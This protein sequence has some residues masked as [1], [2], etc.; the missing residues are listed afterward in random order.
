MAMAA[1]P[2]VPA[3]AEIATPPVAPVPP[4]VLAQETVRHLNSL[5]LSRSVAPIAISNL[6][7]LTRLNLTKGLS[8]LNI[9]STLNQDL[10]TPKQFVNRMKPI[11]ESEKEILEA[12]RKKKRRSK[13][14]LNNSRQVI[15]I[16]PNSLNSVNPN[17]NSENDNDSN[18]TLLAVNERTGENRNSNRDRRN[19]T[20]S[21]K[22][23]KKK[24]KRRPDDPL[25]EKEFSLN[26]C[27]EH[28][29]YKL[30]ITFNLTWIRGHRP[31]QEDA[32]LALRLN[33]H[34]SLFG[35]FDGHGGNS[36][37]NKASTLLPEIFQ[38]KIE[39]LKAREFTAE[40]LK[41]LLYETFL[42]TDK[43]LLK[44]LKNQVKKSPG[45]TGAVVLIHRNF[46]IAAHCGDSKIYLF[47]NGQTGKDL[48]SANLP[49]RIIYESEDHRPPCEGE[50][51][52]IEAYGAQV[53]KN[54]ISTPRCKLGLAVSRG[55]G[56]FEYK[57]IDGHGDDLVIVDPEIRVFPNVDKSI[58]SFLICC[59]GVSDYCDG[60]ECREV[61]KDGKCSSALIVRRAFQN[62][63]LD[64]ISSCCGML[65]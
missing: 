31:K 2:Q 43:E 50:R 16:K 20:S 24:A 57:N 60:D 27:H 14:T 45:S 55:F 8:K 56:D 41:I 17:E 51:A 29:N 58:D 12:N 39:Y 22:T 46:I 32:H 15:N 25:T 61:F 23:M 28:S 18:K 65:A 44:F 5:R 6:Q 10:V 35:I 37:S 30:K 62:G 3:M 47:S 9:S 52:R 4:V 42:E 54:R 26:G 38:K 63:S 59:D 36:I 7:T 21:R 1:S 11:S 49:A 53:L 33:P 48:L 34:L 13:S 40:K 64:N 19:S